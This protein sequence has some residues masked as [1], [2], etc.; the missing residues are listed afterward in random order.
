MKKRVLIVE[1]SFY[2]VKFAEAAKD[3]GH[4]VIA[5][6]SDKN[7][8]HKYGY[9]NYYDDLIVADIRDPDSIYPAIVNSPYSTFDALIPATDYATE[10]TAKVAKKLGK[11]SNSVSATRFA[12]NKDLA[13]IQY[14]KSDV[15][16]AKFRVVK[17]R[18]QAIAA[19]NELGFPLVLKPTNTA[20]SID[21]FYIRNENELNERFN[22]IQKLKTSY[23]D[24]SVRHDYIMEEFLQGPEFS[25]ELFLKEDEIAFSEVTEKHTTEPPFFVELE[26]IFPTTVAIDHKSEIIKTA[27]RAAHALDFH[28]GPLHIEIKL[29]KDGPKVVEVNG[30]P[31]GDNI[32]SDLIVDAYGI[33]VFRETVKLYLQEPVEF[34]K[35]F[36]RFASTIFFFAS[37]TGTLSEIY[38][39]DTMKSQK[40]VIRVDIEKQVGDKVRLPEN[41]DDRIGYA[42]VCCDSEKQLK[43]AIKQ[44]KLKVNIHVD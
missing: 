16:S 28:N 11:F 44:V 4:E 33:N 23:M 43:Q 25:V 18:D 36:N 37:S 20:S 29:T 22:E 14:T 10:V 19:A 5:I 34:N 6:V 40:D 27:Y 35:K 17:S 26:H 13:R 32:T 38:G 21:V 12:R 24:F 42:I 39:W 30:R 15:P 9:E 3:L 2:G 41:S 1:P 7:N 8:P 31:G